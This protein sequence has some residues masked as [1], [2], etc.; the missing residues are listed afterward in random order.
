M[1][2]YRGDGA[3][4]KFMK[5]MFQEVENCQDIA[6]KH[7]NKPLVMTKKDEKNFKKR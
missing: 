7:F 5:A 6:K 1:K 3:I 4:N 2:S